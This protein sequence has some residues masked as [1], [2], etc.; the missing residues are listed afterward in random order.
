MPYY[1]FDWTPDI[2]AHLD[3]HGVSREEFERVVQEPE[4]RERSRTSSRMV[5]FGEC[6]EGRLIAC[7]YDQ[8]D[9][10]TISPVTGY[11]VED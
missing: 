10:M 4:W 3:E 2:E 11:F 5:A 6:D 7:V 1:F 9:S 8:A